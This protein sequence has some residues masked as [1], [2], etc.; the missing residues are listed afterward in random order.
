MSPQEKLMAEIEQLERWLTNST[1]TD[2][3]LISEKTA[4]LNEKKAMLSQLQTLKT[5]N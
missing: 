2:A 1:C 3:K 5:Q 4:A